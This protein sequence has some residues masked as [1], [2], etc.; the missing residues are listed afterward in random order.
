MIESIAFISSKTTFDE[1][2]IQLVEHIQ[3]IIKTPIEQY[4]A[5]NI[6]NDNVSYMT[7]QCVGNYRSFIITHHWNRFQIR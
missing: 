7:S 3:C 6:Y 2:N 4:K 1:Y 5:F